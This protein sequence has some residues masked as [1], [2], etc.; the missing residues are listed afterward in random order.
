[1]GE[2]AGTG[3]NQDCSPR[4]VARRHFAMVMPETYGLFGSPC[5]MHFN[6]HQPGVAGLQTHVVTPAPRSGR[7]SF[8][9]ASAYER[10]RPALLVSRWR[11][12]P[13]LKQPGH[14]RGSNLGGCGTRPMPESR[15]SQRRGAY[16]RS[17]ESGPRVANP[18]PR[19]SSNA[20]EQFDLPA[21]GTTTPAAHAALMRKCQ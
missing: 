10:P 13:G 11:R 21:S 4:A 16:R 12:R 8:M 18:A 14:G 1:M 3:T 6:Y 9:V 2:R 5:R 19:I 17:S 20:F 7:T 15:T